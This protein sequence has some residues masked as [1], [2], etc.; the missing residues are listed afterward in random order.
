MPDPVEKE[1]YKDFESIYGTEK[2][3]NHLPSLQENKIK[4][5]G[6]DYSPTK[7]TA[8]NASI[9]IQCDNCSK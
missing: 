1:H 2:S 5:H 3:Q 6:M 7:Q 8:K 9:V 4:G